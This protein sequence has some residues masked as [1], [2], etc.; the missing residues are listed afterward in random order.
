MLDMTIE[1]PLSPANLA[2]LKKRM[3]VLRKLAQKMFEEDEI[4]KERLKFIQEVSAE[5]LAYEQLKQENPNFNWD[6]WELGGSH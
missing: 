1:S 3:P 5:G 2:L 6:E 4:D